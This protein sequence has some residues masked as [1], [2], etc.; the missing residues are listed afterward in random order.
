MKKLFIF[1]PFLTLILF[2][3]NAQATLLDCSEEEITADVVIS[4]IKCV[5]ECKNYRVISRNINLINVKMQGGR[6]EKA[7]VKDSCQE[8]NNCSVIQVDYFSVC[9]G[10]SVIN[11]FISKNATSSEPVEV[12]SISVPEPV[13]PFATNIEKKF[14]QDTFSFEIKV[15]PKSWPVRVVNYIKR[16]R[17]LF[18]MGGVGVLVMGLI[19]FFFLRKRVKTSDSII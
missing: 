10:N 13:R 9:S 18:A 12:T 8:N 5:G 19:S 7:I 11:L 15:V 16:E 14:D 17:E 1:L 4:N 2:P 6:S 3:Y